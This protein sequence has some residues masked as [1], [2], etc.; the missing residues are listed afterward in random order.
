MSRTAG[1]KKGCP[2]A[3]GEKGD[4]RGFWKKAHKAMKKMLAPPTRLSVEL[5]VANGGYPGVF[6]L[7]ETTLKMSVAYR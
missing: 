1:G 6:D 5:C 4:T 7:S 3:G 2:P